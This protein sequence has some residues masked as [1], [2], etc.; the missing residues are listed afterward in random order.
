MPQNLQ[1]LLLDHIVFDNQG[2]S[3]GLS[4]FMGKGSA[5]HT[6]YDKIDKEEHLKIA[7][8]QF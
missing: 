7:G 8:N 2:W 5:Y 3:G 4:V 6:K 1:V